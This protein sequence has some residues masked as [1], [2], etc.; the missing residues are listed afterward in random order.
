MKFIEIPTE[1]YNLI[2][3]EIRKQMGIDTPRYN[4]NGTKIIMHLEHYETLF[5]STMA[6]DEEEVTEPTYPF[7]V[8][9]DPSAEFSNL[10]ASDEWSSN[11]EDYDI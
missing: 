8:Y 7:P 10:L 2:P 1:V 5:P 3:E 11:E 4:V 9:T 6:I